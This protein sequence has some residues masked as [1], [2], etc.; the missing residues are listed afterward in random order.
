MRPLRE[1]RALLPIAD[2]IP[3]FSTMLLIEDG[4]L[5]G[6]ARSNPGKD[7]AVRPQNVIVGLLLI[8]LP[9]RALLA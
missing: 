6:F 8:T 5:I 1:F 7:A 3:C 2:L 9:K 4:R